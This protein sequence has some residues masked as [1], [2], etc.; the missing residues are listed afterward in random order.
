MDD[1]IF[2]TAKVKWNYAIDKNNV[3]AKDIVLPKVKLYYEHTLQVNRERLFLRFIKEFRKSVLDHWNNQL[4]KY[5]VHR[6]KCVR[7]EKC[8]CLYGCCKFRVQLRIE[9]GECI[10]VKV[11]LGKGRANHLRFFTQEGRPG[12]TWR[13]EVGHWFGLPDEYF[14]GTHEMGPG[15]NLFKMDD[16]ESLMGCGGIEIKRNYVEFIVKDWIKGA[17]GEEFEVLERK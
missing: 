4:G 11:V 2:L 3:D 7:G 6:K 15:G 17:V 5:Y 12:V 8:E 16:R 1:T 13:H 9:V 14:A 10:E